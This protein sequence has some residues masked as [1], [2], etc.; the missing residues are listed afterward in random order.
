M[1]AKALGGS[2]LLGSIALCLTTGRVSAGDQANWNKDLARKYLDERAEVWF[3][4]FPSAERGEGTGKTSCVSCHTL[5]PYV[6]ARPVLRRLAGEKEPTKYEKQLLAQTRQ[7]LE[8]WKDLDTPRL[9]LLYE[10]N[11]RKKLESWGTEAV[12]SSFALAFDDSYQGN[13]SPSESTKTALSILWK[14][15]VA[16]GEQRG[17]WDWLDFNLEPWESK[18]GRYFGAVLAAITVGTAPGYYKEGADPELDKKVNLLRAYL[19]GNSTKQN[20]YNRICLLWASTKMAGLLS[21][22]E[23]TRII[24]EI[25]S[26]QQQDGGWRLSSLGEFE[27]SDAVPQ[28]T[29]SDG[30]ATGLILHVLQTAGLT[31]DHSNV[32]KGLV[33][34][35]ANQKPSGA[36]TGSS[37]NKKREPES[38]NPAK[39]HIGKFMW[40]AAT[41]YAVLALSHSE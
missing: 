20:L 39:A 13:K 24:D 33:W 8:S 21:E 22:E 16:D 29:A 11:E 36:W 15:Q 40:D 31:K 10:F 2:L 30:Y 3:E 41:A 38:D 6:L 23:R 4:S 27:R 26:K 14:T 17:S 34:L 9:Q 25:H 12:L 37:V 5:A 32:K 18:G 35:R 28:E 1:C 19:R 7:R